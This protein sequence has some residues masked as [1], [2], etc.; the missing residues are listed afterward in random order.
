M[1]QEFRIISTQSQQQTPLHVAWPLIYLFALTHW[2]LVPSVYWAVLPQLEVKIPL[3]S[4]QISLDFDQ[5]P[6]IHILSPI[7]FA[8]AQA[9]IVPLNMHN[10]MSRALLHIHVIHMIFV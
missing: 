6:W 1:I 5:I 3:L 10:K 8:I 4:S 7:C 2:R 9:C